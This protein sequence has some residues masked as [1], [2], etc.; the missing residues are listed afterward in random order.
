MFSVRQPV[1]HP[2]T[3]RPAEVRPAMFTSALLAEA[4]PSSMNLRGWSSSGLPFCTSRA[5]KRSCPPLVNQ[6]PEMKSVKGLMPPN[7]S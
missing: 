7:V 4:V 2:A 3:V 6:S 1:S 5:R